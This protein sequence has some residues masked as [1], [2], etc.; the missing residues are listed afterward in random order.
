[1]SWQ[2]VQ[3]FRNDPKSVK[4]K[5]IDRAK[6]SRVWTF[7]G[8]YKKSITVYIATLLFSAIVG[9]IPPILSKELIDRGIPHGTQPGNLGIVTWI[10]IIGIIVAIVT[11]VLTIAQR[12]YSAAIGEGL[13]YD[14]RVSLFDHFQHQPLSFFTR[15]QTGS[16]MS[17]LNND[18]IGAQLAVTSTLGTVVSNIITL[19][20]TLVVMLGLEWRLTILTLLVLPLFVIPA[21]R[22]GVRLQV[23]TR[24]SMNLNS[25]M[26]ATV[27]ERFNVS[28][29]LIVKLFGRPKEEKEYFAKRARR[30]A[31]IGIQSAMYARV[32]F[33][34]LGLIS[35]FGAAMVYY[36]GGRLAI[37]GTISAGTIAAFLL[38]VGQVYSPLTQLTNARVDILTALVSFDRVFEV[39]DF[40]S[41]LTEKPNATT[42]KT[43]SGK[44]TYDNVSFTHLPTEKITLP[45]LEGESDLMLAPREEQIL[46]NVTFEVEPGE[47][48]ALVGPSGAGKT[49]TAMLL[50]RIYDATSGHVKLDGHDVSDLTFETLKDHIG[51]V[52]QDPHLFHESVATNLRYAK[53]DATDEEITE[54]CKRAQIHNMI[55]SL[56]DKYDTLVGERG[57]RLS[58]GEKQRI[59]I[60]RVLLKNPAVVI[61]DEATSHLD[62]ET[63]LQIQKAFEAALEQRTA[64][65]IAHRLTTVI[66]A[67]KIIVLDGGHIVETGTHTQLIAAGG[68]YSDLYTTQSSS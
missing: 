59:A 30:V 17:R 58:G 5:K 47:T 9:V 50:P 37:D 62:T 54:A 41:A 34:A 39:L 42:L 6:V 10:A 44:V 53:P 57:Y 61:L 35:A 56:P 64:I 68:L 48:V 20:V 23:A 12:Y 1:M 67:D 46:S 32:L 33:A 16:I 25:S 21:R 55:D 2:V 51:V 3:S 43:C 66:N 14:L 7:A 8:P 4:G 15:T 29:A 63:E 22:V 19:I 13:I 11:A 24:E 18:V 38:L 40:P 28:G 45:S 27:V 49:T 60:A 65:V 52:T 31:D 36:I 26:N